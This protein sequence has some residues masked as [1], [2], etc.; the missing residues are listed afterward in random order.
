[1]SLRHNRPDGTPSRRTAR[2]ARRPCRRTH[3]SQRVGFNSKRC[4]QCWRRFHSTRASI[5]LAH[6]AR[7]HSMDAR[8]FCSCH[9]EEG[10]TARCDRR[11]TGQCSGDHRRLVRIVLRWRRTVGLRRKLPVRNDDRR[12]RNACASGVASGV[13]KGIQPP[14]YQCEQQICLQECSDCLAHFSLLL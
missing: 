5:L 13:T 10:L 14:P 8:P 11:Q 4:D 9:G 3:S 7:H 1:M 12:W 6:E 2:R